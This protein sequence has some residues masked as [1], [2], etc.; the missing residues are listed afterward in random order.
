MKK[1]FTEEQ[2][3]GFLKQAAAGAPIKELCRK[4]GF[5]DASFYLWRR[6][7]GG[8]D[9][10][11]AKRLRAL[12]AEN[13]KL[14]KLLAEAMLDNEALKVVARGKFCARRHSE[15]FTRGAGAAQHPGRP[16]LPQQH[17]DLSAQH[18]ILGL[19]EELPTQPPLFVDQ[20]Q[21]GRAA[22]AIA[23]HRARDRAV[24]GRRIHT[25][26]KGDPVFMQKRL[27]CHR[28]HCGMMLEHGVQAQHHHLHFG[29][30]PV[31]PLR[32]RQSV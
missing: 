26:R 4:H 22:Q 10:P 2:I 3:I 23:G 29:E 14:K 32:L 18:Q 21:R 7:F 19:A 31:H 27:Q 13:S 5:S 30:L 16:L 15:L 12:E 1:R 25:H 6:K 9:V 24:V 20:Q 11:D 17:R 8:M 28:R